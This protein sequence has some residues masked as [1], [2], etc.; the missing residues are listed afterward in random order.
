MRKLHRVALPAV[1]VLA[2]SGLALPADAAPRIVLDQGHVDVIGIA[3]E[4]GAFDVHV[5]DEANAIEY[6][7]SQVQLVAKP[8]S[9]IA[10]PDDPQYRFLGTAGAR[11]WVLPQ[12]QDPELLWPGIGAE[13]IEAGVF[14]NDALKV[15]IVGV[16]GPADLSIFTTDAFGAPTVL[17]DS[18]NGLPDR[19]NTSAGGHLHANW[20]F[21]AAG[22]YQVKVRVSGTLAATGKQVT[23][24]VATYCFKVNQ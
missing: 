12:V 9:E 16:S 5:H 23:S 13:E 6:S 18:G 8:G 10:V 1:A 21:E 24:A 19:I 14:T 15:D 3:F 20:A 22:T 17:A 2:L 11:A 4:D 7:P